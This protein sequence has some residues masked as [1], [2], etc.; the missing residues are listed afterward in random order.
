[1]GFCTRCGANLV[2]FEEAVHRG[3]AAGAGVHLIQPPTRDQDQ[4]APS[5]TTAESGRLLPDSAA[6]EPAPAEASS[7]EQAATQ[8]FPRV[9]RPQAE[10]RG[11][12]ATGS[13]VWHPDAAGTAR[14]GPVQ[15]GGGRAP[16]IRKAGRDG[17]ALW[18]RP[19]ALLGGA[20]G[21]GA[22]FLPWIRS[23]FDLTAFHFPVRFL[24]TGELGQRM[25]S[26]GVVL[27]GL[28]G[29][30]FLMSLLRRIALLRRFVGVLVLAVPLL[31]ATL[32]LAPKDFSQLLHVLGA[33]AYTA[34]AGGLLL[35]FG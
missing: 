10:A 9:R 6:V 32:G 4:M 25:L 31:F 28:A 15:H 26:V 29:L 20:L 27:A 19:L 34:V 13:S 22:A 7:P 14:L 24:V 18:F 23:D 5:A 33:G 12:D 2:E 1:M 30:G 8:A 16:W 11:E 35:V 3:R 21:V 17:P